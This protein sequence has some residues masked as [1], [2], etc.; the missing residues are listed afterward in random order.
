M[1]NYPTLRQLQYLCAID[2]YM[3]FRIAAEECFITQPTL[4]A[5]IKEME[6]LLGNQVL[7][8][9]NRKKIIFTPFGQE[10]VQTAK[11]ILPQLDQLTANAQRLSE[12]LSGLIRLGI[13]PTIAPYLLPDIL[14]ILQNK[15]PKMAFKITEDLSAS[16]VD[17]IQEG[18]LDLILMAFPYDTE[19]LETFSLLKENFYCACPPDYFPN[20]KSLKTDDLKNHH[21]LLLEDGH[22]LRDHALESCK[23]QLPNDQKLLSATSLQTILQMVAQGYGITLLPKMVVDTKILPQNIKII[24]LKNPTPT[25]EIGF[26]W[27]KGSPQVSNIQAISKEIKAHLK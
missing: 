19:K 16:L 10:V 7:D 18:D 2:K 11:A 14:P 4:S 22:C 1:N 5:A 20:K 9:T 25:R 23:L 24:P 21:L 8:R 3:N 13:I 15:F 27:R 6:Q 12:P 17:K 26:A